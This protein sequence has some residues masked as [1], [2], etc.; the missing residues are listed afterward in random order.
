MIDNQ[1][2]FSSII[3]NTMPNLATSSSMLNEMLEM[4]DDEILS[5]GGYETLGPLLRNKY[6]AERDII[7]DEI[8]RR[9]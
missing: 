3:V 1:I 6:D 5:K 4:I 7:I 8:A 9:N 2:S